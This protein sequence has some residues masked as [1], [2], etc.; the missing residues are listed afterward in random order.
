LLSSK[1]TLN[2][3]LLSSKNNIEM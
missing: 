1:E 2:K 3:K